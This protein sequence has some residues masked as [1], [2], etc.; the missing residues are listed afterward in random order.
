[1]KIFVKIIS[2]VYC[3]V[4]SLK[5]EE[6]VNPS[7]KDAVKWERKGEEVNLR[8][9]V[10]VPQIDTFKWFGANNIGAGFIRRTITL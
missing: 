1:M 5:Q 6:E 7:P 9:L 8:A 2:N 10:F 3:P 4:I